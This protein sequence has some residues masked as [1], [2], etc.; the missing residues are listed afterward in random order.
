MHTARHGTRQK[1]FLDT[2]PRS[3][4]FLFS[5][6]Q[7]L[8][9]IRQEEAFLKDSLIQGCVALFRHATIHHILS[10]AWIPFSL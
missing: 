5:F 6:S 3:L 10:M 9:I 1:S 2:I 4:F 8:T 7:T